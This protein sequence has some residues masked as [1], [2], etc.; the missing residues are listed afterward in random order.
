MDNM[1]IPEFSDEEL[2]AEMA[3]TN[4]E[5]LERDDRNRRNKVVG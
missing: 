3:K 2:E 4:R 1:S 5:R